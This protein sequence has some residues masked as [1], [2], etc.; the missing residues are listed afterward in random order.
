MIVLGFYLHD[1]I[2][3]FYKLYVT[4]RGQKMNYIYLWCPLWDCKIMSLDEG[5]CQLYCFPTLIDSDLWNPQSFSQLEIVG[6]KLRLYV[7]NCHSVLS[8]CSCLLSCV[9]QG[10]CWVQ[11]SSCIDMKDVVWDVWYER[12]ICNCTSIVSIYAILSM[13]HWTQAALKRLQIWLITPTDSEEFIHCSFT[14]HFIAMKWN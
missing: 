9:V 2:E 5:F 10:T 3:K 4:C 11:L 7:F 13:F 8:L 6:E 12:I 14:L 1:C